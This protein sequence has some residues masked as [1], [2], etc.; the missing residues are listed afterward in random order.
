M[1]LATFLSVT[2]VFF[3]SLRIRVRLLSTILCRR[4]AQVRLT[5]PFF[6]NW[7]RF[8]TRGNQRTNDNGH[9]HNIA[10]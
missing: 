5:D 6:I 10:G 4:P 7:N 1:V 2:V 9:H 3:P 8:C